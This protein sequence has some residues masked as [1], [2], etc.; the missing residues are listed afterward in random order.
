MKN[1]N[2]PFLDV[3]TFSRG[4]AYLHIGFFSVY[5]DAGGQISSLLNTEL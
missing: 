2:I 5:Q 3:D 4:F 1:K